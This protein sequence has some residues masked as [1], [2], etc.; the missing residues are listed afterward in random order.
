VAVRGGSYICKLAYLTRDVRSEGRTYE[1][2]LVP[3]GS[4]DGRMSMALQAC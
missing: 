2:T 1:C 4:I 3:I